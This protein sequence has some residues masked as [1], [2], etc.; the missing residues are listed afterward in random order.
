MVEG[1]N[2]SIIVALSSNDVSGLKPYASTPHSM[3][4]KIVDDTLLIGLPTAKEASSFKTIMSDFSVAFDTSINQD[5]SKLFFFNTPMPIQRNITRILDFP[6]STLTY[7][8]L[9]VT[10]PDRPL[11]HCTWE[12]LINKLEKRLANLTF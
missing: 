4:K 7:K 3:H 11:A 6:I 2:R 1:I 8:Y 9:G 5:K 10:L 12:A